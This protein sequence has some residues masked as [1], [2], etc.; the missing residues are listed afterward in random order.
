MSHAHSIDS[1]HSSVSLAVGAQPLQRGAAGAGPA[2]RRRPGRSTLPL[3]ASLAALLAGCVATAPKLGEN[4]GT[5][6]GAAGGASA[7]NANSKLEKC[8]ETLGTLA[9]QEDT[10]APW[11]AQLRSQQLGTTLPVLRLM[12]QQ[13]NCFVIV[14]RGAAMNNMAQERNLQQSGEMRGGSNFGKGQ[15]VAADYTMSPSIQFAAKTGGSAAGV[16]G[17]LLGSIGAAVVGGMS[18]NEASTTLLLIDN[19]SGVQISA[20]EGTGSNMDFSLFGGMLG[21]LGAA[22][23]G[24]YSNTPQ[25]KVIV[26]AFA[27]SFN[28][29]VMSLKNYKAQTVKGGLGTG[30]RL[31]V[32][33]GGSAASVPAAAA[34]PTA[35]T[36]ADSA[37]KPAP[38][39]ATSASKKPAP[40]RPAAK[41]PAKA[42]S[43]TG[44]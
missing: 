21:G 29:M 39:A 37:T 25:G 30:G 5:V 11:Y 24:A 16:A 12:V 32:D 36:S 18:K 34:V 2:Q 20:S 38:A 10:N 19:R 35:A 31:N 42:A 6:S 26:A 9:M 7:E 40:A 41:P 17:A 15:M 22:G 13:S 8:A 14:E 4:K 33:G 27:D 28:Q 43:A 23:G 3:L 1:P 44:R